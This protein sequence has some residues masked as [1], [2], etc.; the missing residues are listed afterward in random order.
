MCAYINFVNKFRI[1]VRL[2]KFYNIFRW[3]KK[4]ENTNITTGVPLSF[5]CLCRRRTL[6]ARSAHSLVLSICVCVS[7][8]GIFHTSLFSSSFHK[9]YRRNINNGI[10][11]NIHM[12]RVWAASILHLDF[13]RFPFHTSN[14][15]SL[16]LFYFICRFAR[17]LDVYFE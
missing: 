1:Y 4:I 9:I 11:F 6:F 14:F 5:G 12:R 7:R 15:S 16:F 3:E 8:L 10:T 13:L 2:R 17:S